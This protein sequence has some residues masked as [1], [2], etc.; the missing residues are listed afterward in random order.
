MISYFPNKFFKNFPINFNYYLYIVFLII[1]FKYLNYDEFINNLHMT[2]NIIEGLKNYF[3]KNFNL[4][5]VIHHHFLQ[6]CHSEFIID[7]CMKK[8]YF[9]CFDFI[10]VY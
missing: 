5:L 7:N 8:T 9:N 10:H 6:L 1:F 4:N 3:T 2:N